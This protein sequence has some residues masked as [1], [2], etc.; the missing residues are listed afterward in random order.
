MI[1]WLV[2][3][4]CMAALLVLAGCDIR[5]GFDSPNRFAQ[6]DVE[7]QPGSTASLCFAQLAEA[8]ALERSDVEDGEEVT[9]LGSMSEHAFRKQRRHRQLEWDQHYC[10]RRAECLALAQPELAAATISDR[11]E[12]CLAD[13]SQRRVAM[14]L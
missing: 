2:R 6:P 5:F 9:A 10:R 8:D 4:A 7:T 11:M 1:L 13:R 3:V 14:G 12:V